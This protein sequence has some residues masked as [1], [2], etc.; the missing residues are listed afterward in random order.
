MS[1]VLFGVLFWGVLGSLL[2]FV[3]GVLGGRF[4]VC[5]RVLFGSGLW[6][7]YVLVN[8]CFWGYLGMV[9]GSILWEWFWGIVSVNVCF[10]GYL[11]I[12]LWEGL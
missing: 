4:G 7:W 8:V 6:E 12:A 11:G 3:C 5:L 9:F 1:S 10:W 2:G